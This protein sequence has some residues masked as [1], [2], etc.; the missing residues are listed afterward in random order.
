MSYDPWPDRV[1]YPS[2]ENQSEYR[3]RL[4]RLMVEGPRRWHERGRVD[5]SQPRAGR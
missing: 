4:T 5:P 2:M 1:P 3:D